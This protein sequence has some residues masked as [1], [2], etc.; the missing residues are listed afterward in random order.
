MVR[1]L[2]DEWVIKAKEVIEK[3]ICSEEDLKNA[4]V[5]LLNIIIHNPSDD[6]DVNLFVSIKDGKLTNFYISSNNSKKNIEADFTV[7]GDYTTFVQIIKGELNTLMALL[8]NRLKLKGD[9]MK[10]IRFAKSIDKINLL[11]REIE[12]EYE[13]G[14]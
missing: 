7:V 2:S 6:K 1:F 9:K 13:L 11:L 14:A 10:A 3:N 5:S 12:T 8:K 4:N